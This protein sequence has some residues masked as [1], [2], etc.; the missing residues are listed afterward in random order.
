MRET[1]RNAVTPAPQV[2]QRIAL[3]FHNCSRPGRASNLT[4]QAGYRASRLP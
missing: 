3:I 1:P 4:V 2:R